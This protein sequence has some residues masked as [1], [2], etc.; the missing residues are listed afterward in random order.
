MISGPVGF[1]IPIEYRKPVM[2]KDYG[3][4][5]HYSKVEH[6]TDAFEYGTALLHGHNPQRGTF[7]LHDPGADQSL[8]INEKFCWIVDEP[9]NGF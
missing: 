5:V 4:Q 7:V 9:T 3:K 8:S 6:A 2:P 1:K